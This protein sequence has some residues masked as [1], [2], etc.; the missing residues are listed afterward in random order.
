MKLVAKKK[1]GFRNTRSR[2]GQEKLKK[3]VEPIAPTRKLS[4]KQNILLYIGVPI[5]VKTEFEE[6]AIPP[7]LR[8]RGVFIKSGPRLDYRR[9]KND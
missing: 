8:S 4:H 7:P 9:T 5:E 6:E 2:L 3:E 1:K